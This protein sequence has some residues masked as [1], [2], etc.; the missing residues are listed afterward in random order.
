MAFSRG[1]EKIREKL[2]ASETGAL[3]KTGHCPLEVGMLGLSPYELVIGSLGYQNSYR[4]FNHQEGTRCERLFE[5][6]DN[7]I[8]L[9]SGRAAGTF[10]VLAASVSY[11]Q[12]LIWLVRALS[13]I[14][15]PVRSADRGPR[16]PIV[17]C[18]GPVIT[19]NPET[20]APF[21]DVCATGDGE[22]L[23]PVFT[24]SW[25]DTVGSGGTRED[26]LERLAGQPGFYVPS[27]YKCDTGEPP[28]PISGAAP[29]RVPR[30]VVPLKGVPV[31]STVIS[32]MA[33]FRSMFMVEITRGCRGRCKFCMVCKVNDPFR[34]VEP[35][36]LIDLIREAPSSARSVGLVGANLCDHPRLGDILET[37]VAGGRRAG[38]SSLRIGT[39]DKNLLGQLR[40]CRANSITL[41]PESASPRLLKAIGKSYDPARLMELVRLAAEQGFAGIKL[42]YMIG[43]PD[44]TDQDRAMLTGQL[45]ELAEAASGRI[46][47]SLSVNP[48][49]PKPQTL[50]QDCSMMKT[51]AIKKVLRQ[52]KKTVFGISREIELSWQSPVEATAQAVLSLGGRELSGSVEK[53]ALERVRLLDCLAGQGVELENLLYQRE[54]LTSAHPWRVLECEPSLKQSPNG[55]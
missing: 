44:E 32:S 20:A 23:I 51:A 14:G 22:Q 30:A 34:A 42:Y 26:L 39:V 45:R 8:S 37:I 3:E 33:H 36:N 10:G 13:R 28:V 29:E 2:L 52:L 43:L 54:K 50:W 40:A 46:K 24:G 18:G 11:E 41:A 48:F 55:G 25:L 1:T 17:L 6:G 53:A 15:V 9:E 12:E 31:H 38:V 35:A 19:S 27:L 5:L 47:L 16:D 4:L 49:V 21:I 7:W